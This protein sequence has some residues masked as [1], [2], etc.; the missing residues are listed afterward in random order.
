M[1]VVVLE[2]ECEVPLRLKINTGIKSLILKLMIGGNS[3]EYDD[4]SLTDARDINDE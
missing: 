3:T 4:T 1:L 2:T